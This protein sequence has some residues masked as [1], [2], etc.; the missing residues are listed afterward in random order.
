M[1]RNNTTLAVVLLASAIGLA[2]PGRADH[3]QEVSVETL[4]GLYIECELRAMLEVMP[5]GEIA[6]C[7]DVYEALK[8][9]AF[10]GDWTRLRAWF[11]KR[12]RADT[13]A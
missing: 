9:R 13:Q 12:L 5:A 2:G 3:T 7:S 8:L 11:G 10:G 6:R 1:E 4:K